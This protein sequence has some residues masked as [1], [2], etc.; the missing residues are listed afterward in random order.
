MAEYITKKKTTFVPWKQWVCSIDQCEFESTNGLELLSHYSK[1]HRYDTSFTSKCLMNENCFYHSSK[2]F[3]RSFDSLYK[4][5]KEY[6]ERFF[7]SN[8]GG[9][10][11]NKASSSAE[12]IPQEFLVGSCDENNVDQGHI[13]C[14]GIHFFILIARHFVQ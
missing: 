4:H 1:N 6:H 14:P 10:K 3:F 12:A 8:V 5:L 13:S 11:Q 7:D 2:T 9:R